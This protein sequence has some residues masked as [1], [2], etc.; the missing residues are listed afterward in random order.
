MKAA[1]LIL[2]FLLVVV[3]GF[4]PTSR[5]RRKSAVDSSIYASSAVHYWYPDHYLEPSI[6]SL[7][8]QYNAQEG[9]LYFYEPC[10]PFKQVKPSY[11][12][13]FLIPVIF[14]YFQILSLVFVTCPT[15]VTTK[16][17]TITLK[18]MLLDPARPCQLPQ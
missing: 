2:S 8:Y 15:S 5:N 10:E 7:D 3:S 17:S 4:F 11:K 18:S 6:Q 16:L 12:L 14:A 13:A 1:F 9:Y